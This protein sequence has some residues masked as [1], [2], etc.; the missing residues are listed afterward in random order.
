MGRLLWIKMLRD[1]KRSWAAYA[2]CMIIVAIGFCGYSVL[3]LC[4]KNLE[5]SERYFFQVTDFCD[6]FA[7]VERAPESVGALLERIDGVERA[8]GRL[9]KN[10]RVT[11][12]DDEVELHLVSI[13][14]GSMNQPKLSRGSLPAE[15]ERQM[16]I[17]DAISKVRKIRPGEELPVIIQGKQVMLEVSGSGI[18]PENI[19]MIK[20]MGDL[21]PDPS[22]YDA[23]FM[24]YDTMA[25]LFS[26]AG[27][28]NSFLF[29]LSPGAAWDD[30]K[31][32]IERTLTPYGCYQLNAS[33]DQLS[34]S[35]LDEEIK[36]LGKMSGV[37][38]FLFLTVA[39]VILYITMSRLVEQQR[40]QIGTLLAMG[41]SMKSI[42]LH[43]MLYGVFVGAVGGLA[44]GLL[45][46]GLADPMAGFYR[47]YFN[48]PDVTASLSVLYLCGG[49]VAAAVF[50]GGV[51]WVIAGSFG[52]L[53]PSVALRPPAPKA[54][55]QSALERIPGF[56]ALFTVP[57]MMAVRSLS[58]NRKR[59]AFSIVGIS[60]AFM[61]TATLVSMNKMFDVFIFDYWEKTQKQDIMVQF[62]RPV[63]V[64]DALLAVRHEDIQAAEG[65]VD[66]TATLRGPQGEVDCTIQGISP[67]SRLCRLFDTEGRPVKVE[68]EG[69]VLSEH[70]A[71]L[72]DV[73]IGD[74]IQVK[75]VYPKERL[76]RVA[77]TAIV[78]QYMGST[79][80][81]SYQ[82]VGR[83]SEYRNVYTSVLLKA[84]ERVQQ[85][86]LERLNDATAVSLVESRQQRLDGYHSMMGSMSGIMASMSAMGVIIGCV[87]IYVSS[88][89]SFEELKREI[90]TLMALGLRDVQCLEVISV[91]QWLMSIGGMILGIPMAMGVSR[92]ISVAMASELYTIP[93]FVDGM[94]LLR[95]VGLTMISVWVSSRLMLRKMRKLS[96]VELLRERE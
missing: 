41:I 66:V 2:I 7:V 8:E 3:E 54:A 85:E 27:M 33:E 61:I 84:P 58:R 75:V 80:Y 49:T 47:M 36:Q 10:V 16:V 35:M 12:Y 19:Y 34:V 94:S 51:A 9:E 52:D 83:I 23:A 43:Y 25:G 62:N 88:L 60:F 64:D 82:G 44:G 21:F 11:A 14:E 57:G 86:I 18:T 30:V 76:S 20:D 39:A 70:M 91:S 40:T 68:D 65:V 77:V 15:G 28:V 38:P 96:P 71:T 56:A 59:T 1:M 78:N 17:G 45:G 63:S 87:V 90:S 4:Q 32:E 89:I 73:G 24:D 81:M 69:I 5:E 92:W 93:D 31:D 67:D 50:C 37:V 72:M 95:A 53:T 55:R 13:R 22:A 74:T 48:L 42:Q 46:Y 26:E 79:A 29:R 6:G